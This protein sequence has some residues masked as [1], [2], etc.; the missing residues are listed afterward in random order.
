MVDTAVTRRTEQPLRKHRVQPPFGSQR[1]PIHTAEQTVTCD[2]DS[3]T[4]G[5]LRVVAREGESERVIG[6]TAGTQN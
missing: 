3:D 1:Q 5:P 4:C 6:L 2:C